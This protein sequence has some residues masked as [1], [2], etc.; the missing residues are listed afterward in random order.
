[1]SDDLKLEHGLTETITDIKQD[2]ERSRMITEGTNR[3]GTLRLRDGRQAQI[4]V[5]VT[6]DQDAFLS[7]WKAS[8]R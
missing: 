4:H 2:L 5:T 6:T 8:K 3:L 7:K 1:M